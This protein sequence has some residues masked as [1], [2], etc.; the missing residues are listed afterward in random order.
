MKIDGHYDP[1]VDIAWLRFESYDPTTVVAEDIETGLREVDPRAA[2][3]SVSN[4]GTRVRP[5]RAISS[6]CC[7]HPRLPAP[8]DDRA[9]LYTALGVS[10]TYDPTTT[11]SAELTV[12]IPRSAKNVS[13]GGESDCH[14]RIEPWPQVA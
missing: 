8:P 14:W 6:P 3:S 1:E 5:S 4:T 12:A 9:A 11:R 2:I 7:R 10:A 13:G